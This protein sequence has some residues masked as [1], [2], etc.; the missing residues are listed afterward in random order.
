MSRNLEVFFRSEQLVTDRVLRFQQHHVA[1]QPS[2][3]VI[4]LVTTE[5][6]SIQELVGSRAELVHG[7]EG[8]APHSLFG[9]IDAATVLAGADAKAESLDFT[10]RIKLVSPVALLD[11][12]VDSRIFQNLSVK[13]II[14]QVL[15][16]GGIAGDEVSLQLTTEY[17]KR[18]FCV[19][20]QESAL[21]FIRRLC[22]EEGIYFFTDCVPGEHPVLVFSDDS[23]S[24]SPI[25]DDLEV[26]FALRSHGI[27][28]HDT[29]STLTPQHRV[30]SGSFVSRDFNFLTPQLEVTSKDLTQ[31]ATAKSHTDLEVYDYPAAYLE[32][33]EGSTV[34]EIT[35]A[36]L[37]RLNQVRLEAE[38]A[39]A[40]TITATSDSPRLRVG[41]QFKLIDSE[42][43]DGDYFIFA[44][45]M[46]YEHAR[47][48]DGGLATNHYACE[49]ELV[50]V[51]V[52]YRS[53]QTTPR[54]V[55]A[56][57]QTAVVVAPEGSEVEEIHTDEHGRCQVKFRWDRDANTTSD[58]SCW[59]RVQQLQTS[60]S[61]VLPRVHW[62]V[63][64]EF[65]EGNPDRPI[66]TGRLYNGLFMPPYALPEG[67]T[68]TSL[69][70]SSTPGGGGTNEIRYEDK[71][72]AEEVMIHSQYD[73]QMVTA[74]NKQK[75][76]GNN[77]SSFVTNNSSS[78]VAGNA[79]TK[80][81]K[82]LQN[83]IGADQTVSV[84]GNRK[85]E[86]NAVYGLTT[87]GSTTV[88]VGGNQ[89]E[90]TGN[91]LEA[92]LAIAAERAAE[93]LAAA[94][95]NVV[96]QVT[97]AVQGAVDQ[98]LAPVTALT[99][100]VDAVA[101]N[102][103]ALAGG[104]LGAAAAVVAGASG[105]PG[106]GAVAGAIAGPPAAMTPVAGQ[107]AADIA[108]VNA[109][110]AAATGMIQQGAGSAMNAV[111][112]ALGRGGGGGGGQSAE[113]V[114]GPDGS[115]D[116]VDE[117]K[118][119]KG[120]G[121]QINA[122]GSTHTETSA[123]LRVLAA[124]NGINTNVS[125]SMTQT[126]G[127]AHLELILGNRAE[128]VEG[129]KNETSIGL[130]IL[131]KGDE[132]EHVG[133]AKN[134]MVGGAILQTIKGDYAVEASAPATLIGSIHKME[135]KSSI[136]F[137]AGASEVVMDGSGITITSPIFTCTLPKNHLPK[138]VSDS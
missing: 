107:S 93:Y 76:I 113:N 49:S 42:G 34:G 40:L 117:A 38:Q 19:Q 108:G 88:T 15:E 6:Q 54:P 124:V 22:E 67:K 1:G 82:G 61:M 133:G 10:Y 112:E 58:A 100:Q 120:P 20:Y 75:N 71:A 11:R 17:P 50:P 53:P 12:S 132:T 37:K 83:D 97:A 43:L 98:V 2:Y 87:G 46:S 28:D 13:E 32:L 111:N 65:L 121:H 137:K 105:L 35:E 70:T 60:G 79:D 91:P 25:A 73:T 101:G 126:V 84:G 69:Q 14:Q 103:A 21:A 85:Q 3:A 99:D 57:P 5:Y 86:V 102:M 114:A 27:Q 44:A 127:A 36:T 8:E 66:V 62:E 55:I 56:G 128:S 94:A 90:M 130:I 104:D 39:E 4:D 109:I 63:I 135:A 118:N 77:E 47:P 26:P 68:R 16:A 125:A 31:Q 64:V 123:A 29:I 59:I 131:S 81:T 33:K 30:R 24:A 9:R 129:M 80:I 52:Q 136:T 95:A 74:N 138:K 134:V 115:V 7:Y 92:I 119:T 51:L 116:G 96:G 106:A 122:L 45:R 23:T 41:R 89:F 48:T 78:Q 110:R 18:E 72:G